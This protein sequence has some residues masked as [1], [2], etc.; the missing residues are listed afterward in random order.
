LSQRT[1]QVFQTCRLWNQTLLQASP[2]GHSKQLIH[3]EYLPPAWHSLVTHRLVLGQAQTR[4]WAAHASVVTEIVS[5]MWLVSELRQ[6]DVCAHVCVCVSMCVCLCVCVCM[7]DDTGAGISKFSYW[8]V[9]M[10]IVLQPMLVSSNRSASD[11]W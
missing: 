1:A 6:C 3:R 5:Q 2:D 7:C 8:D 4:A 10:E 9:A 11:Q